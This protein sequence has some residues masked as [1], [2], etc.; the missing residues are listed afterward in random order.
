MSPQSSAH[1][2]A[3]YSLAENAGPAEYYIR[4]LKIVIRQQVVSLAKKNSS[5]K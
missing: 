4:V 2:D 3:R 5:A 1:H